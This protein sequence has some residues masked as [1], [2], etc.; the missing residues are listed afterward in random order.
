MACYLYNM[1]VLSKSSV[2][3]HQYG[4]RKYISVETLWKYVHISDAFIWENPH[5]ISVCVDFTILVHT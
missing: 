1:K 3:F 2:T 4:P 5:V